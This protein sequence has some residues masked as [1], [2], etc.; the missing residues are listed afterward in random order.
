VIFAVALSF[1]AVSGQQIFS[2]M[3]LSENGGVMDATFRGW[4]GFDPPDTGIPY[5]A[6]RISENVR[7][8]ADGTHVKHSDGTEHWARDSQ[9]RTRIER[10][11][12]SGPTL[13]EI[14]DP[15]TGFGYIVD[16][17]NQVTHRIAMQGQRPRP[18]KKIQKAEGCVD[19][20]APASNGPVTVNTSEIQISFETL[21]PQSIDGL[22]AEGTR[23]ITVRPVGSNGNDRPITIITETWYSPELKLTVLLKNSSPTTGE[24]VI[25]MTNISRSEPNPALFQPPSAYKIV[26]EQDSFTISL[27]AR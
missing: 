6:D 8:L 21:C 14:V 2:F 9:G 26:D 3:S 18:R 25:R 16:E 24:T 17:Q 4:R 15:V 27:K 10:P 20:T 11:I 23:Q 19:A 22:M 12:N 7:T 5:S 13:T 1:S